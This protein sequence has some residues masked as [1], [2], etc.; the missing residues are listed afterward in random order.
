MFKADGYI[1]LPKHY[2][3]YI[4]AKIVF[5]KFTVKLKKKSKTHIQAHDQFKNTKQTITIIVANMLQ[6]LLSLTPTTDATN[7]RVRV[8]FNTNIPTFLLSSTHLWLLC[9][10]QSLFPT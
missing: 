5:N 10:F 4:H 8:H 9:S 1:L 7:Y 6:H 3:S 2:F